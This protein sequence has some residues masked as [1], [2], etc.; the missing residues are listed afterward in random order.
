M[1][2]SDVK[3]GRGDPIPLNMKKKLMPF[4]DGE[5]VYIEEHNGKDQSWPDYLWAV[6]T[7]GVFCGW[8]H[9]L[10]ILIICSFFSKICL[11][12][13]LFIYSYYY[14]YILYFTYTSKIIMGR[15]CLFIYC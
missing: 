2:N 3:I 8:Y 14:C 15:T 1:E 4:K 7:I 5:R 12:I 10:A 13:I 6:F 11:C 9:I